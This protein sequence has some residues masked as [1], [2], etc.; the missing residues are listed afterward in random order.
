MVEEEEEMDMTLEEAIKALE[1]AGTMEDLMEA[2]SIHHLTKEEVEEVEMTHQ[3][4][5]VLMTQMILTKDLEDHVMSMQLFKG[6]ALSWFTSLDDDYRRQITYSWDTLKTAITIHFMSRTY[7]DRIKSK[8]MNAKYRDHDHSHETPSDY[9]IR[10]MQLMQMAG[11][12]SDSELMFE[13]MNGAP[14]QW[15][16]Y[17]DVS[18]IL[19]FRD[20]QDKIKWHEEDLMSSRS[21][22]SDIQRQLDRMMNMLNKLE[23]GPKRN[24]Q[25]GGKIYPNHSFKS[26]KMIASKALVPKKKEPGLANT[27]EEITG[28][29]FVLK[30]PK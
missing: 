28:I 13:I 27:V 25:V 9:I 30:A 26:R 11:E 24:Q 17:I 15:R 3:E 22:D 12:W 7:L 14:K 6:R 4:E 1:G 8:A 21:S 5:M 29:N 10:K 20:F 18:S 16:A 19:T 2:F 23:H